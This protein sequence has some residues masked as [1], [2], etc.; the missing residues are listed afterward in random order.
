M[1]VGAASTLIGLL[2]LT[3]IDLSGANVVFTASQLG[4]LSKDAPFDVV[5]HPES[6]TLVR[7]D[8]SP[9]GDSMPK[10][11]VRRME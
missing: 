7:T 4:H 8:G 9:V 6:V 3:K 1:G 11:L 2:D 10:Q 5:G